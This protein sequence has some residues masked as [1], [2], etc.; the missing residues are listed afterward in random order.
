MKNTQ[1][2]SGLVVALLAGACASAPTG[3]RVSL[4]DA[5]PGIGFDDLRY[6]AALHRVLVPAGRTGT[7]DLV[8]PDSLAVTSIPGFGTVA[9]YSGDHDDGFTEVRAIR[10]LEYHG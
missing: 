1:G 6:S 5:A 8:D 7:L 4:P 10:T 3:Q 2:R 9:A